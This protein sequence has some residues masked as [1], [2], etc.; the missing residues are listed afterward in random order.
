MTS[1]PEAA[2]NAI[3]ELCNPDANMAERMEAADLLRAAIGMPTKHKADCGI[4][5][6]ESDEPDA[7]DCDCGYWGEPKAA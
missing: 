7:S 4:N 1:I 5:T 6:T 2:F 3:S